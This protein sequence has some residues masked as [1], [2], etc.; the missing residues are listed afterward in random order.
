ME[1]F[2][3]FA[4]NILAP[5]AMLFLYFRVATR[6]FREIRRAYPAN[7]GEDTQDCGSYLQGSW[8]YQGSLKIR[9]NKSGLEMNLF[10]FPFVFAIRVFVPWSE[11]ILRQSAGRILL[12]FTGAPSYDIRL[13]E[14]VHLQMQ[15]RLHG[16]VPFG[17]VI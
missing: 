2:T 15:H 8:F 10:F 1:A 5:A 11:V 13:P 6:D 4:T 7:S 3:V 16:R 14:S 17:H 9:V 12:G